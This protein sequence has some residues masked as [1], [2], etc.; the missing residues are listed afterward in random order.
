M[1]LLA[2]SDVGEPPLPGGL[3]V[4]RYGRGYFVYTGLSF[5]RRAS[6][7]VQLSGRWHVMQTAR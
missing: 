2:C 3:L 4:A 1:P 6:L 7:T 5:F